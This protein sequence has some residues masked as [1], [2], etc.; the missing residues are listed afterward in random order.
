MF[1]MRS[2]IIA[3]M[4]LM[5]AAVPLVQ[6]DWQI[7]SLS[8]GDREHICAQNMAYCFNNCNGK[9]PM[10]FCNTTTMGW[11]CGCADKTPDLADYQWPIVRAECSGRFNQ[12]QLKCQKD[13]V[14]MIECS[15]KCSDTYKCDYGKMPPS[16]LRVKSPSSVPDYTGVVVSSNSNNS[17]SSS[18]KDS[19]NANSLLCSLAPLSYTAGALMVVVGAI[20]TL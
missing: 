9:A 13:P 7:T 3:L 5:A 10:N 4:L 16:N 20:L 11:N 1:R 14:K 15:T 19:N 8:T 17:S 18:S 12:C 2:F 6:A